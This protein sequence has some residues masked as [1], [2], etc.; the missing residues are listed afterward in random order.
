MKKLEEYVRSIPDFPEPG[1]IFRDV[2]SILQDADGLKLAIDSMQACLEGLDVDVIVGFRSTSLYILVD[3]LKDACSNLYIMTDDGSNG[4]QGFV[5]DA[6]RERF[7]DDAVSYGRDLRFRDRTS[8]TAPM[9]KD[10]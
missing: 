3:E 6:L 5:T 10:A 7:G 1:V 2:T 9:H 8:D 4:H